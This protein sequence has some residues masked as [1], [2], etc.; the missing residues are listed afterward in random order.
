MKFDAFISYRRTGGFEMAQLIHDHL[1][2]MGIKCYLDL[3]QLRSG[4]FD[5]RLID[6]I[7]AAQNFIIILSPN[8]LDRCVDEGD[9]V[10][11]ELTAA[12][13]M[14]K[15]II[16]IIY[17]EF[18][19]PRNLYEK[20]PAEVVGLERHH[21]VV[22]SREYFHS[23]LEKIIENMTDIKPKRR[24]ETV[25]SSK[26]ILDNAAKIT[27][28]LSIDMAF[29][30][31]SE[32]RRNSEKVDTLAR[33]YSD[34]WKI[35]ILVNSSQAVETVCSHMRQPM[36]KY[37]KFDNSIEEWLELAEEFPDAIELRILDVP[38]LHRLYI[39]RGQDDGAVNVKYYSYG[40]FMPDRDFRMT[41]HSSDRE[42]GIYTDEFDYLWKIARKP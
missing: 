6:E 31:G 8:A 7:A 33:L 25:S 5:E 26:F 38:L 3:E 29:H 40:N 36:K 20:L 17:P 4:H 23:M 9:W 27:K 11:R 13:S 2:D 32:W 12:I 24:T 1:A 35:R 18:S 37:V 10:R 41:F 42:W 39:V 16:P 14:N 22:A 30:A 28:P 15:T 21:G 19:W 34:G